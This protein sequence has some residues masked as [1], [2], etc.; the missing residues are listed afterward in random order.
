[1]VI[2]ILIAKKVSQDFVHYGFAFIEECIL[3]GRICE[4]AVLFKNFKKT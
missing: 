3:I 4:T 2:K 1:M